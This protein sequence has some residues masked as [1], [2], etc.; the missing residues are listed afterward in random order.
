MGA[1]A[2]IF[3]NAT[4]MRVHHLRALV[5][6]AN[7]IPPVVLICKAAARPAKIGDTDLFQGC[8]HIQADT[9]LF[10]H[11]QFLVYPETII[12]AM[13]QVLGKVTVNMFTDNVWRS[14]FNTKAGC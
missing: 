10:R 2:V 12:D 8:Y 5:A 7:A 1:E 14:A 9:V 4:P 3:C 11:I 6:G 13:P